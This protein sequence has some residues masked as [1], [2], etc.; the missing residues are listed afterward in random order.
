MNHDINETYKEDK[1]KLAEQNREG[2]ATYLSLLKDKMLQ[3][4]GY[5]AMI[6]EDQMIPAKHRIS[7]ERKR[8]D[9]VIDILKLESERFSLAQGKQ[10][11]DTENDTEETKN[12]DKQ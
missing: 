10:V 6:A 2:F 9:T 12:N 11:K 3:R 7:A 4:M 5:L 1:V 8:V